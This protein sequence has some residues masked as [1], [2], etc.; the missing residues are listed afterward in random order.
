MERRRSEGGWGARRTEGCNAWEMAGQ[1]LQPYEGVQRLTGRGLELG[2]W[3]LER[4]LCITG[5]LQ[6]ARGFHGWARTIGVVW[7]AGRR[8]RHEP[9]KQRLQE[10]HEVRIME[11]IIR[12]YRRSLFA[13]EVLQK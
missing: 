2:T 7:R 13:R 8:T 6:V 10:P 12:V 5:M 3:N 9:D 4:V 1:A 11:E